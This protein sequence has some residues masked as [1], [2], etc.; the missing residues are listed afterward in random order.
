MERP[1][2]SN[3]RG[4]GEHRDEQLRSWM[5]LTPEQRL[6]WLESAKQF[7]AEALGAAHSSSSTRARDPVK[8]SR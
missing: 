1:E 3:A 4:W 8:Q 2:T 5:R 7:A 6:D